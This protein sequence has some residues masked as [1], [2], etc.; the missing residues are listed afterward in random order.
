MRTGLRKPQTA[1]KLLYLKVLLMA[2]RMIESICNHNGRHPF[3]C[4]ESERETIH[5]TSQI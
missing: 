2:V 1:P 5:Q 3:K 4:G